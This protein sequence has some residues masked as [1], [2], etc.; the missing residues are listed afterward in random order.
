MSV[1]LEIDIIKNLLHIHLMNGEYF[2]IHPIFAERVEYSIVVQLLNNKLLK[3]F[4]DERKKCRSILPLGPWKKEQE[5]NIKFI[6][7]FIH[8][9]YFLSFNV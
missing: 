7:L 2:P 5:K 4:Y 1:E 8:F 3:K 9:S 6:C